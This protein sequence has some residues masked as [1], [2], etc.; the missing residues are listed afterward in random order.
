[1]SL[2][3]ET[4]TRSGA[5]DA[6]SSGKQVPAEPAAPMTLEGLGR[7]LPGKLVVTA[8]AQPGP[9]EQYRKLAATLHQAQASTGIKVVMVASALAGEG[10]TLTATNLALTFSESYHRRV[11]LIDAD[12]R[13]PTVHEVFQ[14]PNF[15]GLNDG[16]KASEEWKPP[17]FEI[18][19]RL[20]VLTAGRPNPDPMSGLA[21][22]RMRSVI[23]RGAASFDWV[24][25]DTPPVGLLPDANLL[26]AM[27]DGVVLIISAGK[28]PYK[29]L[30]RAVEALGRDRILGV[31]LNR[32]DQSILKSGYGYYTYYGYE[33]E[34][35]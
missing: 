23:R 26:A 3:K 17:L 7:A 35:R 30:E 9:V 6:T 29:L 13:R 20:S 4:P 18:S 25:V 32:V 2:T 10:K 27:V 8:N 19:P 34:D 28:T 16:L 12:L 5:I 22:D 31:V 14:L 24:I 21:S 11:L 1:M 15:T 33:V